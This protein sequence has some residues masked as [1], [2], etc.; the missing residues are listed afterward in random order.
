[1]LICK[2]HVCFSSYYICPVKEIRNCTCGQ[3]FSSP[4]SFEISNNSS[5]SFFIAKHQLSPA[6][7]E[8]V[9]SS[10]IIRRVAR[11]RSFPHM[12]HSWLHLSMCVYFTSDLVC[13]YCTAPVSVGR[14]KNVRYFLSIIPWLRP[15]D[16]CLVQTG[17]CGKKRQV[18]DHFIDFTAADIIQQCVFFSAVEHQGG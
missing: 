18:L 1:M 9:A 10:Q 12:W 11:P 4:V 14:H 15:L 13:L 7:R 3:T 5:L 6:V 17:Y 2:W 16:R 8:Q